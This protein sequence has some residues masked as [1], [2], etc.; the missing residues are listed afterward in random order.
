MNGQLDKP[1]SRL[2]TAHADGKVL[3]AVFCSAGGT[4]LGAVL[5]LAHWIL[6][7]ESALIF[8]FMVLTAVALVVD[9]EPRRAAYRHRVIPTIRRAR[10]DTLTPA[11]LLVLCGERMTLPQSL[12]GRDRRM[13]LGTR[14]RE[15]RGMLEPH[16][17]RL[18]QRI[19]IN[20]DRMDAVRHWQNYN[21]PLADLWPLLD[22][23]GTERM[24]LDLA[25]SRV[26]KEL[27]KVMSGPQGSLSADP[28][29]RHIM[30]EVT[31][32]LVV[33]EP[34]Q[35]QLLADLYVLSVRHGGLVP[36][37]GNLLREGVCLL[38]DEQRRAAQQL[39][40]GWDHPPEQLLEL[41]TTL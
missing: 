35:R 21:G 19:R 3:I 15:L 32:Q 26:A 16:V 18:Q 11:G 12:S 4:L 33:L 41:V 39:V 1:L 22:L 40:P 28:F 29:G 17:R 10:L 31:L 36:G 9:V 38:D 14:D 13:V 7:P 8:A 6:G 27:P 24:H 25:A 30:Q 5:A 20:A 23:C 34:P 2:Q 37:R